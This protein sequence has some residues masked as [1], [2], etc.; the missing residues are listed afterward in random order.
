MEANVKGDDQWPIEDVETTE[1]VCDRCGE[2]RPIRKVDD[3]FVREGIID[4][5]P[6][7]RFW[8]CKPC[9]ELRLDDV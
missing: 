7:A 9:Y 5:D 1:G 8:W 6:A 4:G 2:R 3:P